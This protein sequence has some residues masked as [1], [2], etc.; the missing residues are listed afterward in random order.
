MEVILKRNWSTPA[1][2]FK[3]GPNDGDATTIPDTLRDQLPSDAVIVEDT[4]AHQAAK[5]RR[6][7]GR[8]TPAEP[9]PA[10]NAD[11]GRAQTDAAN[12]AEAEAEATRLEN[13]KNLEAQR[14]AARK[15]IE[16]GGSA[17]APV[18]TERERKKR[19]AALL[20]VQRKAAEDE[21]NKE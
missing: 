3:A 7:G 9:N 8:P 6:R 1:G 15:S 11:I 4:A 18:E 17:P 13:E 2:Y 19:L 5:E 16:E 14:E 21:K 10:H 12:K 20:E